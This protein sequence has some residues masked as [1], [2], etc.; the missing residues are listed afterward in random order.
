MNKM[1]V[2]EWLLVALAIFISGM[3]VGQIIEDIMTFE[4]VGTEVIVSYDG[5]WYRLGE[6]VTIVESK[7]LMKVIE[8]E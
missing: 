8:E 2:R 7:T 3:T 1:G 4:K 6:R 5:K